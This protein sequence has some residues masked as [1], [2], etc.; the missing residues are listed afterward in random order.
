MFT[1]DEDSKKI[2]NII[3]KLNDEELKI[4][5]DS[6]IKEQSCISHELNEDNYIGYDLDVNLR[7]KNLD[8]TNKNNT[9]T[10]GYNPIYTSYIPKDIKIAKSGSTPMYFNTTI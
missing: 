3:K 5:I 8:I 1:L 10:V 9:F 7:Y 6:K 4:F 2:L